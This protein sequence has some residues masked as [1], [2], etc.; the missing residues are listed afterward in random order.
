MERLPGESFGREMFFM[1][2]ASSFLCK[3]IAN[4]IKYL[5]KRFVGFFIE[6]VGFLKNNK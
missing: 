2:L 1:S 4:M 6:C 3:S 5:Y